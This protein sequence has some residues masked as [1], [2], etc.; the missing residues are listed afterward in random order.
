MAVTSSADDE[1]HMQRALELA[2]RG[3]GTVEPNP[4]VGCV[5]V[6]DG[7]IVGEGWHAEF[8]G[9]HAEIVALQQAQKQAT[10][11]TVYVTL[12]PCCHQGK[13]PPCS[14]ALVY[15]GVSRVVAAMEDPFPSVDGGGFD[16]LKTAGIAC[17]VGLLARESQVLNAPYLKRLNTGRPWVIAKWAA[18]RDGKMAMADGTRWISNE[19]SREVVQQLRG[20]VDAIIVGS[21]TARADDP[22]LTARP[23]DLNDVKRV[24]LRVVV[25]SNASMSPECQLVRTAR[26]VPVLVALADNAPEDAVNRLAAAGVQIFRCDGAT[27]AE[28]LESLLDELGRRRMTNVLVEGGRRLL[29]TLFDIYAIDEVH[30][31]TAP[32]DA[33]GDAP[34]APPL[35]KQPLKDIV[36]TDLDGDE[37]L[38]ARLGP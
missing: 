3:E 25:D 22:L 11:A 1:R 34:L 14:K 26:E 27:H 36:T 23:S 15:A 18:T 12:E 21:G 4:L 13:T 30:V 9:P 33:G 6:R 37:H 29:N 17:E 28:R 38:R 24:A 16:E 7:A 5:I 10:G 8:G 20:R 19:R 31:F 32:K 35:K 2:A